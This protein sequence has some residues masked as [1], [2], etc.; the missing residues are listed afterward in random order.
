MVSL[1]PEEMA[2]LEA[3]SGDEALGAFVRRLVLRSLARRR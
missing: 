1:T 2:A 3:A